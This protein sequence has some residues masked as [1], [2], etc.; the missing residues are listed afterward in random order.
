MAFLYAAL[1]TCTLLFTPFSSACQ[2]MTHLKDADRHCAVRSRLRVLVVKTRLKAETDVRL[3]LL[4]RACF[5]SAG[6]KRCGAEM[7]ADKIQPP[8]FEILVLLYSSVLFN[9]E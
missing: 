8:N 6:S 1:N 5:R 3:Q 2:V 7:A 4:I 9:F